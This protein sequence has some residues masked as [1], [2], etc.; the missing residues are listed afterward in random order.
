MFEGSCVALVTPMTPNG[1]I[2]EKALVNLV[3]WHIKE[4]TSAIVVAGTTGES[5]TLT[6]SEHHG[7]VAKV[8]SIVKKRIPVIAGT[9]TNATAST[10]NLTKAAKEIGVDACLIVTPYYNRPTQHGL[11]EHYRA[12]AKAVSIPILLYNNP[13]RT[14]CDMQPETVA[15][16]SE[17]PNIVGIKEATGN[18]QRLLALMEKCKKGFKYYSGDDESGLEF[19]RLGGHGVISVTANVVPNLM[20]KMCRFAL[21]KEFDKAE[22]IN[23]QIAQLHQF[24]FVEANPIPVKWTLDY[25]GKIDSGIRLPLTRLST[26]HHNKVIQALQTAGIS[27]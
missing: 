7:L 11:I 9:G 5:E 2:D 24:L 27:I 22:T 20:Q 21:D 8:Y 15:A 23:K 19:I 10:I 25:M 13:T 17:V 4:G 18:V 14:A 3:E 6:P 26:E 16:V 12:I 1:E